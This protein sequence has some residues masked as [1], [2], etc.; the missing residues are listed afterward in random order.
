VDAALR[1]NV[2]ISA[3]AGGRSYTASL[4]LPETQIGPIINDKQ[5]DSITEK[6]ACSV[7]RGSEACAVRRTNRSDRACLAA[8]LNVEAG[9]TH[10]NDTTVHD[11]VHP[12]LGGE[13]QSGIGRFGGDWV[14]DAF[15]TRHWVSTQ[16]VRRA[17]RY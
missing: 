6:V 1:K 12:A 7:R 15:T 2:R 5:L 14:L 13:K 10:V 16:H 4:Q 11:D 9:M 8:A 3:V 17:L